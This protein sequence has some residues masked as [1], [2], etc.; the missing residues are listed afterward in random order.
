MTFLTD[1][2]FYQRNGYL[3]KERFF[4][5]SLMNEA[6]RIIKQLLDTHELSKIAEL[7]PSNPAVA[8]RL[9]MPT[10]LHPFFEDLVSNPLLLDVVENLIGSNIFFHYS[11][12]NMKGPGCGS[13]VEWHQDLSYYPHTNTD[14]VSCLIY[15]DDA[16]KANG[17]LQ[18]IPGS[19]QNGIL[20]HYIDGYFRGKVSEETV[21]K[22][23]APPIYL[24]APAGS[25]IF[26]HCLVLHASDVNFS[27]KQRRVFIPAYRAAD[28]YPIYY[29]PHASH[30]E[31]HVKLLRGVKSQVARVESQRAILP[32]AAEKFGSLYALQE[33]SHL[34]PPQNNGNKGY[35][36]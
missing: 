10:K 24:E 33:G 8:R 30:N 31:A 19:H 5:L 6:D 3:L 14:L 32:L 12:L 4:P 21:K 11:K 7:E 26:T 15:L 23:E 22:Q 35:S 13:K 20:D 16:T 18:I 17:C 29:G 9:W 2:D 27:D 25:V 36:Q 1:K 28:A 34:V